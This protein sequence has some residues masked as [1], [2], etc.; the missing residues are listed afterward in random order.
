MALT[1]ADLQRWRDRL[2]AA[3]LNGVRD[4]Q[5]QNGERVTFKSDSE[6]ARA[7]ASADRMIAGLQ[8]AAPP[9]TIL[10]QTSKGV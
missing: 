5:D 8:G 7:I 10:I 4:L 3:R 1:L 9:T 2:I 6:I